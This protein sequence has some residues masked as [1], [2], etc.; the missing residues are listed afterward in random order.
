MSNTVVSSSRRKCRKAHFSAPSSERRVIMSGS[1]SKEL[2]AKHLTRSLPLRIRD[3]VKIV[4][5]S[6]KGREGQ[7]V[8][9]YRKKWCI[10]VDKIVEE[11][12]NGASVPVPIS[13]SNVEITNIFLDTDRKALLKRKGRSVVKA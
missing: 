6:H 2:R 8:Q 1:L 12:V 13:P 4:R 11:K 10:Y 7:I 9:V 3:T 5:G